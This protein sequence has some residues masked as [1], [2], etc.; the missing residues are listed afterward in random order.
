MNPKYAWSDSDVAIMR[1]YAHDANEIFKRL[2]HRTK[3]SIREKCRVMKIEI[4]DDRARRHWTAEEDN[5]LKLYYERIRRCE[6]KKKLKGR[7]LVGISNRANAL[8]ITHGQEPPQGMLYISQAVK[9]TG[10]DRRILMRLLRDKKIKLTQKFGTK[11]KPSY[12][13]YLVDRGDLEDVAKEYFDH[14][15]DR[16]TIKDIANDAGVKSS[17][18]E[19]YLKKHQVVRGEDMKYTKAIRDIIVRHYEEKKTRITILEMVDQLGVSKSTVICCMKHLKIYPSGK[20]KAIPGKHFPA[21]KKMIDDVA[22]YVK[23][24]DL[25]RE[26]GIHR[27]YFNMGADALGLKPPPAYPNLL[28]FSR[29]DGDRLIRWTKEFLDSKLKKHDRDAALDSTRKRNLL[30]VVA[31]ASAGQDDARSVHAPVSCAFV[32]SVASTR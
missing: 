7:S 16:Y 12:K 18:I 8:G 19:L 2:K 1:K 22:D 28:M 31:V 26:T 21:I 3:K 24:A 20:F 29:E 14:L 10:I 27:R 13:I 6:L 15:N 25:M 9:V 4:K 5:I 32:G 11:A 30:Q 17:S 23:I